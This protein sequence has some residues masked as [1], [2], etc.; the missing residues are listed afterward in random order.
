MGRIRRA[1]GPVI[2]T[3]TYMGR[4][5]SRSKLVLFFS[6]KNL[7]W[8][9]FLW[10]INT[11]KPLY[12]TLLYPL[13]TVEQINCISKQPTAK[14]DW[15]SCFTKYYSRLLPYCVLYIETPLIFLRI[16]SR[17]S[18]LSWCTRLCWTNGNIEL[19]SGLESDIMG[20]QFP[21]YASQKGLDKPV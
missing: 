4:L 11:V 6:F 14:K 17:D 2:P 3:I 8:S 15:K 19:F 12:T 16:L 21:R 10:S 7:D 5:S 18:V 1:R 20:T 9:T 13:L